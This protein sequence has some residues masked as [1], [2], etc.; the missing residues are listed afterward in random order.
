MIETI[1]R[2]EKLDYLI[3]TSK[4][5]SRKVLAEKFNV[6]E[7][8]IS[9]WLEFMRDRGAEIQFERS[10]NSYS[11]KKSGVFTV[12]AEFIQKNDI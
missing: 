12:K 7:R 10:R 3:R 1:F 11:Y 6:S 5:G 8:T 2:L 9:R 4:T